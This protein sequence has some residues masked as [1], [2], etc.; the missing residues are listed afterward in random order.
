MPNN[1]IIQVKSKTITAIKTKSRAKDICF[2]SEINYLYSKK[3]FIYDDISKM[4]IILFQ[5]YT[6]SASLKNKILMQ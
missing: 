4:E 1:T 6:Q 3:Q 2:D 5:S